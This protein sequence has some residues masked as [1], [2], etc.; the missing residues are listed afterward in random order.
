MT[1]ALPG[2]PQTQSA[3]PNLTDQLRYAVF[4]QFL[5]WL[6]RFAALMETIIGVR[7]Q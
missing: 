1:A 2:V 5:W 7:L 3:C 6:F 4:Q